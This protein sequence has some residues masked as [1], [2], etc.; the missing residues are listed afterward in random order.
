M[1]YV[2]FGIEHPGGESQLAVGLE[3]RKGFCMIG[4]HVRGQL[5][6]RKWVRL[7]MESKQDEDRMLE[8]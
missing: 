7:Y 2:K 5:T 4:H 1:I 3:T 6:M 8:L